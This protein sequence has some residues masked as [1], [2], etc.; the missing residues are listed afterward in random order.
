MCYVLCWTG[1]NTTVLRFDPWVLRRPSSHCLGLPAVTAKHF[2]RAPT[3][4][5]VLVKLISCA[6][7]RSLVTKGLL[8]QGKLSPPLMPS[9]NIVLQAVLVD[10]QEAQTV[11]KVYTSLSVAAAIFH[12]TRRYGRRV[13]I[14]AWYGLPACMSAAA[15]VVVPQH[16]WC[17]LRA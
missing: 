12:L 4:H 5:E 15:P 17:I 2:D 13:S 1:V 3:V 14:V 10:W 16:R 11:Q 7:R 8:V 6:Q 9:R